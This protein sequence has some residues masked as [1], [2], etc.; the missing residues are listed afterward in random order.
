MKAMH[1]Q[2]PHDRPPV[3]GTCCCCYFIYGDQQPWSS[4]SIV[5]LL[6]IV[7]SVL[8][9]HSA[10][11]WFCMCGMHMCL[12]HSRGISYSPA[13][14]ELP[15]ANWYHANLSWKWDVSV[16]TWPHVTVSHGINPTLFCACVGFVAFSFSVGP[17]VGKL[18]KSA[19]QWTCR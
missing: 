18:L 13:L 6:C 19:L 11:L 2:N 15:T 1:S 12:E 14:D 8:V 3:F 17:A 5:Q 4:A 16:K 10:R 7:Q 9:L